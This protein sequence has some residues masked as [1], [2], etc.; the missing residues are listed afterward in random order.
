MAIGIVFGILAVVLGIPV[1]GGFALFLRVL[2]FIVGVAIA[3]WAIR[4]VLYK[5]YS[6]FS[7]LHRQ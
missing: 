3:M 5:R 4:K 6:D 1:D 7:V 2:G